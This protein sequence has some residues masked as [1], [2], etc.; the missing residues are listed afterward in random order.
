M[1][2]ALFI[3]EA[4]PCDLPVQEDFL[5]EAYPSSGVAPCGVD[6]SEKPLD[7]TDRTR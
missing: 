4:D 3:G 6:L 5:S 1:D 7:G 2:Q